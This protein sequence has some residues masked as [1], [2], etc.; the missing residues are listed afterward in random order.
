[1][2]LLLDNVATSRIQRFLLNFLAYYLFMS[3]F[4]QDTKLVCECKLETGIV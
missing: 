2:Q 1:M 4:I 3:E